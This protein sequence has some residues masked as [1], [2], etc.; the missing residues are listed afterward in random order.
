M[1][2]SEGSCV[3]PLRVSGSITFA[4]G[5]P[6]IFASGHHGA[7]VGF[8]E[9]WNNPRRFGPMTSAC[10]VVVREREVKWVL[11]G[12]EFYGEMG[13]RSDIT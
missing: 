4:D 5:D 1:V 12:R 13:S 11:S 7:L 8:F 10:L 9:P 3:F 2:R 6:S